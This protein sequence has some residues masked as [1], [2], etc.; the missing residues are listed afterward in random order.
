MVISTDELIGR[1]NAGE[2][3][4]MEVDVP[5]LGGSILVIPLTRGELLELRSKYIGS[6]TPS[7]L[8][9]LD[10]QLLLQHIVQPR[11]TDEEYN[12]LTLKKIGAITKALLIASG[13]ESKSDDTV[14]EAIRLA[15]EELK[16]KPLV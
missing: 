9:D 16:K 3:L 13:I 15:E 4:P 8:Q 5:E 11:I 6:N 1:N 12:L 2:L 7:E 10:R 14:D